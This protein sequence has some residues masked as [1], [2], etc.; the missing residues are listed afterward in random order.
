[1]AS[2]TGIGYAEQA[3]PQAPRRA[4]AFYALLQTT[5]DRDGRVALDRARDAGAAVGWNRAWL[6]YAQAVLEG[7]AGHRRRA[8]D[9]AAEAEQRLRPYAPWWNHLARRLVVADAIKDSW[10]EP[11]AWLREATREFDANGQ[12]KLASACR[13]VLRQS[14]ERAPRTGRGKAQVPAQMRRLGVT[15]R[16]MDVLL[17]LAQELSNADIAAKL[18]ISRK[19]VETHIANLVG[20]TGQAGRRDLV[21]NAGRFARA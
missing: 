4:W 5:S 21:A 10:G 20:K 6:G 16:E 8:T 15:S 11:A 18:F 3:P 19:T 9:L 7:R 1:R 14:G 17:L 12:H 13:V 2:R